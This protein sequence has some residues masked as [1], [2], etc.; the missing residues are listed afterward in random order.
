VEQIVQFCEKNGW[1]EPTV[2]RGQYNAIAQRPEEDIFH[3]LRKYNI[4]SYIYSPGASGMF[5]GKIELHSLEGDRWDKNRSLNNSFEIKSLPDGERLTSNFNQTHIGGLEAP[6]YQ[7]NALF[8]AA[9]CV[10]EEAEKAGVTG[11]EGAQRL[12]ALIWIIPYQ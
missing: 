4:S 1:I 2:Y 7:R 5:S 12:C 8:H 3:V 10:V 9:S 6:H 11:H